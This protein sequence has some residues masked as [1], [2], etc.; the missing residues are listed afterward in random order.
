NNWEQGAMV[1]IRPQKV[2]ERL[3]PKKTRAEPF[4]AAPWVTDRARGYGWAAGCFPMRQAPAL[5]Q[6]RQHRKNWGRFAVH[7]RAGTC[8]IMTRSLRQ[9]RKACP[10]C[11]HPGF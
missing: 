5:F 11:S 6:G 8:F 9:K 3:P 1:P 7:V 2:A 4:S 10:M